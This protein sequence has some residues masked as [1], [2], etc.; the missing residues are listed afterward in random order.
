MRWYTHKHV[1]LDNVAYPQSSAPPC[2]LSNRL[3]YSAEIRRLSA[4]LLSSAYLIV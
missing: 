3:P 1:T 4:S 2:A